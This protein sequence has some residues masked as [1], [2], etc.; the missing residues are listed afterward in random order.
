MSPCYEG[1]TDVLGMVMQRG[2]PGSPVDIANGV[3][4]EAGGHRDF[5][6]LPDAVFRLRLRGGVYLAFIEYELFRRLRHG[7]EE[8]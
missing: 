2:K 1:D 8:M 3:I 4:G 7:A 5:E 6:E